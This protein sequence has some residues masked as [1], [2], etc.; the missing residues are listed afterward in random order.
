[1]ND[2]AHG[3]LIPRNRFL[4]IIAV[5]ALGL[6]LLQISHLAQL[7]VGSLL[8]GAA[9]SILSSASLSDFMTRY[10]YASLF[11]LMVLESASLPVPSE[12]VLPF[13][14]YLVFLGMLNFWL[15]LLVASVA[16]LTGSLV[17]YYL[18]YWL[19]RPFV[20]RVLNSFRL[21][22]GG[23]DR[24]EGWF[25]RSGQWTVFAARFV[26]V[27]RTLISLP[28]GLFR[29]RMASFVLM[30]TAGV[31]AWSAALI[32]AGYLAGSAWQRA[33]SSG[34]VADIFGAVAVIVSLGYVTY[35]LYPRFSSRR[36][37]SGS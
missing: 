15:A 37:A 34:S 24:A 23:L 11:V 31:V 18:A 7:P 22:R 8:S 6:G 17:D 20:V 13:A 1:M 4:L 21:H 16:A 29:M 27:L 28:A 30:T 33:V 36:R 32:Y 12:V 19:G 35:F 3:P 9:G 5:V 2:A 10:G 14:G 26:P 25:E